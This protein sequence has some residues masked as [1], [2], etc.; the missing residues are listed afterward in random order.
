MRLEKFV[1]FLLSHSNNILII[2]M[3]NPPP[4]LTPLPIKPSPPSLTQPFPNCGNTYDGILDG[5]FTSP[6]YDDAIYPHGMNCGWVLRAKEGYYIDFKLTTSIEF[7]SGC[8]K[9]YVQAFYGS[10]ISRKYCG[11]YRL[12]FSRVTDFTLHYVTDA[13]NRPSSR[14]YIG[15]SGE[16]TSIGINTA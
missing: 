15:L 3:T 8:T 9:D 13:S 1:V 11:E 12:T 10:K 7:T 16:F 6:G 14:T 2:D 5:V 4:L